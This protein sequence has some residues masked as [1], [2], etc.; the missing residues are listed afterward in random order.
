M[1]SSP[2][3]SASFYPSYSHRLPLFAFLFCCLPD[4]RERADAS[5]TVFLCRRSKKDHHGTH[6]TTGQRGGR[7]GRQGF[8]LCSH[9][10]RLDT[11]QSEHGGVYFV[12]ACAKNHFCPL[13]PIAL[14]WH[15]RSC[16]QIISVF[17]LALLKSRD[18]F[19]WWFK[20]IDSIQ[21][22]W[23]HRPSSGRTLG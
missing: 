13:E 14:H 1:P 20:C 2:K 11:F 5:V 9:A 18:P 17:G 22:I 21:R 15:C 7:R 10:L 8:L 19:G 6:P 3:L 16:N 12:G 23:C 4:P